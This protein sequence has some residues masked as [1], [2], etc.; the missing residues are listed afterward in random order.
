[1]CSRIVGE[2][3]LAGCCQ[4]GYESSGFINVGYSSYSG[5]I[6][7]V[8]HEIALSTGIGNLTYENV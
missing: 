8:W 5:G 7:V 2:G 4:R 3:N 1:M 6:S